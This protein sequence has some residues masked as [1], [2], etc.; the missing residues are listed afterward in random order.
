MMD[1]NALNKSPRF[2]NGDSILA[3]GGSVSNMYALMI[4]RHKLYPQVNLIF[5]LFLRCADDAAG[6]EG[7]NATFDAS[8]GELEP[9]F[10]FCLLFS[11]RSTGCGPSKDNW[12]CTPVSTWVASSSSWSSSSWSSSSP[13]RDHRDHQQDRHQCYSS[14][15]LLDQRGR[16]SHRSRD[17]QLRSSH[18]RR[19]VSYCY[20]YCHFLWSFLL[21]LLHLFILTSSITIALALT[22]QVGCKPLEKYA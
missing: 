16:F 14:A 8:F 18:V 17:W 15:P 19:K 6:G 7:I 4:A 20:H 22:L 3:P 9:M 11:T 13:S 2:T 5:W 1:S 12:S 21:S 10:K